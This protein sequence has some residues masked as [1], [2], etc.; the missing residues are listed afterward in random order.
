MCMLLLISTRLTAERSLA[1]RPQSP[2][3]GKF[4]SYRYS[5]LSKIKR[6]LGWEGAV[7]ID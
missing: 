6:D 5:M 4:H 2:A 1:E 3:H 7:Q